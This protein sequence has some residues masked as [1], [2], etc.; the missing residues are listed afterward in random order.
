MT[1]KE[2]NKRPTAKELAKIGNQYLG[3]GQWGQEEKPP[4]QPNA[5]TAPAGKANE[6]RKTQRIEMP[7]TEK[8]P[9]TQKKKS[10]TGQID[11]PPNFALVQTLKGHSRRIHSARY[12][13]DGTVK[14]SNAGRVWAILPYWLLPGSVMEF[15]D[16]EYTLTIDFTKYMDYGTR[17]RTETE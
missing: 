14:E 15:Y 4:L 8:A 3:T 9:E 2:A 7:A 10:K 1:A 11:G 6:G 5:T 12:S 16:T 13:P 17:N